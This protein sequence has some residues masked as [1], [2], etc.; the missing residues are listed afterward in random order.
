[1][2]S[3]V[4]HRDTEDGLKRPFEC[5]RSSLSHWHSLRNS[6]LAV[7]GT[8]KSEDYIK[9]ELEKKTNSIPSCIPHW[10]SGLNCAIKLHV[11]LGKKKTQ[12]GR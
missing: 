12:N 6:D 2:T 7:T 11:G 4:I 1:M 5:K 3:M 9:K 8:L 10:Y